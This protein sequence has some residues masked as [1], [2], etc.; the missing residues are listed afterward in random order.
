MPSETPVRPTGTGQPSSLYV[1]LVGAAFAHFANAA[2]TV[3]TS[4]A[5]ES[6]VAQAGFKSWALDQVPTTEDLASRAGQLLAAGPVLLLPPWQRIEGRRSEWRNEYE[7]VLSACASPQQTALLAASIPAAGLVS[8]MAVKF[9]QALAQHWRPVLVLYARNIL[10][11]VHPQFLIATIFLRSRVAGVQLPLR[12]F[13]YSP[14]DDEAVVLDDFSKLLKR[15]GGRGELGY[16]LRDIPEPVIG[17]RS[18]ATIP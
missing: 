15:K 17:W 12:M 13:E 4:E 5:D 3:L 16:V 7:S 6:P 10:P 11:G 14:S 2:P 8:P 9:R 18:V 1:A